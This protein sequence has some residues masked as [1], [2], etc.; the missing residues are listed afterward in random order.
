MYYQS[1]KDSRKNQN[2]RS[3]YNNKKE[4]DKFNS[5]MAK[6]YNHKKEELRNS[7]Q[8]KSF[9]EAQSWCR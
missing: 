2:K 9:K 4:N 6:I 7:D 5:D 1:G 8:L 3:L